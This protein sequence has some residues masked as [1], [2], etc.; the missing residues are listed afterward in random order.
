M[1]VPWGNN[2]P[3]TPTTHSSFCDMRVDVFR[4]FVFYFVE[5]HKYVVCELDH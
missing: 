4:A 1:L 5:N 2:P 3:S